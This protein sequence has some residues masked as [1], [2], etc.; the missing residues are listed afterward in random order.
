MRRF[1]LP[2]RARVRA[3]ALLVL[4]PIL[5]VPTIPG[6]ERID[7]DM[8][9]RIREEGFRDSK[10]MEIASGLTDGI[11]P[12]LTGSPNMKKANEWTRDK[13][14]GWGLANAH[15][16]SW[17]PFGRGWSFDSASVRMTSPDVAQ[18][19]AIPKAWSPGTNGPIRGKVIL[20]KLAT[21]EDIER[22]KGKLAGRIVL[23]APMREVPPQQKAASERYDEKTLEDVSHYQIPP[24]RPPF[25]PEEFRRRREFRR[26]L[27]TFLEQEKPLAVID[28]GALDG[29]T[30]RVQQGGS[31]KKDEPIGVPALVMAIE[32]YGRIARLLEQKKDVELEIDVKTRF[33]DDDPMSYNTVAEIPGTDR[34]G[35]V[36]MLGGHM[37]SW[38]AGTGATDNAAGVAVAMEAVRILEALGARPR[39]TIRIALWSGEEQGLLGSEAYVMQHFAT[40]PVPTDPKERENF[41]LRRSP[42]PLTVKPEHAKLSAYFNV[43]NGTGKIR[44]IYAQENAAV[45]PIFEKWLEPLKDL[46]ATTVTMR[47]TRGTDHESFDAVGLPAFQF[48][49]DEIEYETRTHHTNQD[50]YERLQREDLMQASVVLATFVWE[51]AMRDAKLPRKPMPKENPRPTPTPAAVVGNREASSSR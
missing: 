21:K 35:E 36:V 15:L 9:T 5:A 51:A 25:S 18:L 50:V 6:E 38:H 20:A 40:R 34:A 7:Y 30:F 11:G 19:L 1:V 22:E 29:G 32:H 26:A 17:G 41:S 47:N 33:Y 49:Q 28:P 12:R 37:D 27:N 2:G 13:L 31:Y 48:I 43:D 42:G 24:A 3:A 16:E 39:R 44:G 45:V 10:V 4:L 46:G 8:V 14:A 23:T